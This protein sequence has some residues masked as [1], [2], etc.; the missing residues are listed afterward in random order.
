MSDKEEAIKFFTEQV[1]QY[2]LMMDG[3][4]MS[5]PYRIYIE[6]LKGIMSYLLKPFRKIWN[7]NLFV[8]FKKI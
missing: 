1:R 7:K 4:N 6:K 3:R 2:N 5:P 8:F